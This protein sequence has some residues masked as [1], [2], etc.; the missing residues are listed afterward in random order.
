MAL[1]P[2]VSTPADISGLKLD[3]G[4]YG[5][6][7]RHCYIWGSAV[8]GCAAVVNPDRNE[9]HKYPYGD[10]YKHT[11]VLSGDGVLDGGAIATDGPPPPDTLPPLGAVIVFR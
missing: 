2:V 1:D 11:I 6:E 9:A 4:V 3:S 7:Y 8:G 5:R 10:K